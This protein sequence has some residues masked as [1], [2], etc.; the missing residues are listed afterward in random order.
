MTE[1]PDTVRFAS[2]LR[3]VAGGA[4]IEHDIA[5]GTLVPEGAK[6]PPRSVLMGTPARRVRET[7]ERDIVQP[8]LAFTLRRSG[9][10]S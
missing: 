7:T 9:R 3:L 2:E 6:F 10:R 1:V 4:R 5:A 8:I